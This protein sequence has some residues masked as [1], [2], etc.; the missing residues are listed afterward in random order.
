MKSHFGGCFVLLGD[1]EV[2]FRFDF[3]E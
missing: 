1:L 2:V 3:I